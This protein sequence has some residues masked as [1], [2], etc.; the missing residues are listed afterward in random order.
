VKVS[1]YL[2]LENLRIF[3]F[4]TFIKVNGWIN[5]SYRQSILLVD[6]QERYKI[7]IFP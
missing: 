7:A 6:F 2:P 5:G 3:H 4:F 1:S